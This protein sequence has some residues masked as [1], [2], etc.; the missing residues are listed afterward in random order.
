MTMLLLRLLRLMTM[1]LMRRC[2][3]CCCCCCCCCS[4]PRHLLRYAAHRHAPAC[5]NIGVLDIFGFEDFPNNS[6][7][8]LCINFANEKLQQIFNEHTFDREKA[9]YKKEGIEVSDVT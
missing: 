8:Q 3:C 5:S 1:L 7:E 6:F 9:F 2:D 4:V